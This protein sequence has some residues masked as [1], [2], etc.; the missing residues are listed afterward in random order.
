MTNATITFKY[1]VEA[2][3]G[4]SPIGDSILKVLTFNI[5]GSGPQPAG[6]H[7]SSQP[8]PLKLPVP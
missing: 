4:K 7:P 1:G 2:I 3:T 5:H 6:P 8:N